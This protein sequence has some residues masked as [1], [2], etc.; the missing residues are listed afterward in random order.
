[1]TI[2][3]IAGLIV[4]NAFLLGVGGGVLWGLRG[5]RW[6]RDFLRLAGVAYLLGVA[7]LFIALTLEL[8][9][10]IP[11]GLATIVLTGVAV[12][13]CG[14][15]LGRVREFPRPGLRAA[16]SGTPRL[17]I[18]GAVFA[19]VILVCLEGLFRQ[20]RLASL[21]EWDAWRVWTIRAKEI[22][23]AGGLD[24]E[25]A[26]SSLISN[27][28]S[29]PPAASGLQTSA[30]FS[31]GSPDVVT[32]HLEHWF[33]LAGFVAALAGVLAPRVRQAFLLPILLL[34]LLMPSLTERATWALADLALD[35]LVAIAALFV[36]LWL[37]DRQSWRIAVATVLMGGAVLTKREGLL[38]VACVVVAALVASWGTRR[39]TWPRLALASLA[40]VAPIVIWW[41]WLFAHT[42]PGGQ[43]EGGLLAF[44]DHFDRAWPSTKLVVRTLFDRDLWLLVPVIAV[45][46]AVLGLVWGARRLAVFVMSFVVLSA[47]ACTWTIWAN[48]VFQFSQG[49]GE[50]PV[51]RQVG[52]TILVLAALTPLLLD[53]V[54][55]SGVERQALPVDASSPARPLWRNAL[56]WAIVLAAVVAYPGSMLVGYSGLRLP[57]G[58]PPFPRA[59]ECVQAPREGAKVRVVFGYQGSYSTAN[60][61]R[62]RALDAGF[63]GTEVAQ[64]GCGRLR[65]FEDDVAPEAVAR[66]VTEATVEGL[67]TTLE[68]DPDG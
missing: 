51:V 8:V 34:L 40:V 20:G 50:S 26:A 32:L 52:G 56:P 31:M 59:D 58:A 54:W 23:F 3:A 14:L 35:Y 48:V 65:V 49:E 55:S 24:P 36:V 10:G 19:A 53:S 6:W 38:L 16:K 15:L 25:L 39:W 33:L 61:L 64:D 4:L 1:M 63:R 11:I 43:P 42:R 45:V 68:D 17:T 37:E 21:Y 12:A 18:L 57:G 29:Y 44:I 30:F 47:A 28:A 9:I 46:G 22:Y 67:P 27:N 13:G 60:R 5:W 41:L 2:R 7:T 66:L 62:A